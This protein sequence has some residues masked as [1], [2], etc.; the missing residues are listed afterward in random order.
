MFF[1]LSAAVTFILLISSCGR[2]PE[3]GARRI[4]VLQ[5]YNQT[6]EAS[7]DWVGRAVAGIAATEANTEANTYVFE[8]ANE[9]EAA[10]LKATH[11]IEGSFG[12]DGSGGL[13]MTC[14][15]RKGAS[16]QE[17]IKTSAPSKDAVNAF[18]SEIAHRLVKQT[19]R[20]DTQNTEAIRA[21]YSGTGMTDVAGVVAGAEAALAL[22]P[23]FG[24]AQVVRLEGLLASGQ[25]EAALAALPAARNASYSP[26]DRARLALLDAGLTGDAKRTSGEMEKLAAL[27]SDLGL[28][29]TLI[30]RRL[31][32][33]EYT[34]AAKALDSAI[35]LEPDNVQFW[36]MLAYARAYDGD[37]PGAEKAIAEYQRIAP[38]DANAPDTMG[39]LYFL[40]GRYGDAER[41]FVQAFEKNKAALGGG[42]AYRAAW[43]ALMKGDSKAADAH[44]AAYLE[45]RKSVGDAILPV[46][47]AIWT[48]QLG[49]PDEATS[50]L[51]L[52]SEQADITGAAAT[53]SLA[54]MLALT[55]RLPEAQAALGKPSSDGVIAAAVRSATPPVA[56]PVAAG[57]WLLLRGRYPE[58]APLWERIY[59]ST[60][61]TSASD[62]RI[63]LGWALLESGNRDRA[64]SLL[65]RPPHPPAAPDPG[66]SSFVLPKW[67]ELRKRVE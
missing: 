29:K 43:A 30:E 39:E 13:R 40:A 58:A 66:F 47:S 16:T 46:R 53:S 67:R 45:V 65:Q 18:A 32:A 22:D 52:L 24:K 59:D 3:Q 14:F 64:K 61:G 37:L 35:R 54:A 33:K 42:E 12:P 8:A 1:R 26:I 44:F 38:E 9:R 48:Y 25:R 21:F 2:A 51:R 10:L 5:I 27:T 15:L 36:N 55:G 20:F 56:A 63:A 28:W 31:T 19:A 6:S 50:K 34:G 17:M 60:N 49:R 11:T 23:K 7:L 41:Q 62:A 57:W 4:A